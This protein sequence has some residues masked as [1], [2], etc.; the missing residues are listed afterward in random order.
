MDSVSLR[1]ELVIVRNQRIG[2]F[3]VFAVSWKMANAGTSKSSKAVVFDGKDQCRHAA[4]K[5]LIRKVIGFLV[6][7]AVVPV[8]ILFVVALYCRWLPFLYR[9]RGGYW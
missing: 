6:S 5:A 4:M 3:D 9:R 8:E 2:F 7:G 1:W